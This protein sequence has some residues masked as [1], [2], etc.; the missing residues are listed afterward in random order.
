MS[1]LTREKWGPPFSIIYQMCHAKEI[2]FFTCSLELVQANKKV[3]VQLAH[4]ACGYT[5]LA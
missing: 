3:T 4:Q 2:T 1:G 5:L